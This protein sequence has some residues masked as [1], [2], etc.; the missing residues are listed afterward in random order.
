VPLAGRIVLLVHGS[1]LPPWFRPVKGQPG[2]D[3]YAVAATLYDVLGVTP[4]SSHEEPRRAY[5]DR[6]LRY[7]PDRQEHEDLA[8]RAEAERRMQDANAAWAVLGDREARAAYDAELVEAGILDPPDHEE[9]PEVA[10]E[11]VRAR[12]TRLLPLLVVLVVLG[13]IFLFTAYAGSGGR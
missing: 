5:I 13:A 7:H 1:T 11:P 8:G 2:A 9:G 3:L 10:P 6:A 4:S 12:L